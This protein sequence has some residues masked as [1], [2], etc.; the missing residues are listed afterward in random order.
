MLLF[1]LTQ[2]ATNKALTLDTKFEKGL[3][4]K[5]VFSY[6]ERPFFGS[7]P[8]HCIRQ[9][10]DHMVCLW[11]PIGFASSLLAQVWPGST[12]YSRQHL[13][14]PGAWQRER[15]CLHS[16][17]GWGNIRNASDV[18]HQLW[19]TSTVL[20]SLVTETPQGWLPTASVLAGVQDVSYVPVNI[21]KQAFVFT[22]TLLRG[23]KN[24]LKNNI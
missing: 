1:C 20:D 2:H 14:M 19:F 8:T 17:R 18:L 4:S 7:A 13:G 3:R 11:L 23:E 10:H 15:N 24:L 9:R 21:C 12:C 5:A 16:P 22:L 6:G